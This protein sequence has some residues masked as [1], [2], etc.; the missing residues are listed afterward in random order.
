MT[1]NFPKFAL[2]PCT[3]R[4]TLI[5][6]WPSKAE[7]LQQTNTSIFTCAASQPQHNCFDVKGHQVGGR[8]NST[9]SRC[10]RAPSQGLNSTTRI[11]TNSYGGRRRLLPSNSM[12]SKPAK[13]PKNKGA[14]GSRKQTKM[15]KIKTQKT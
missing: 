3:Y 10:S 9:T 13:E 15:L 4:Q 7:Q 12:A 5:S 2:K 11:V 1:P 8:Y 14:Q 6:C